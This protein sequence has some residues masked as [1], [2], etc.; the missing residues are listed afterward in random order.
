MEGARPPPYP[1]VIRLR[2][3][4]YMLVAVLLALT[5]GPAG[6][7]SVDWSWSPS[8]GVY[9]KNAPAPA[10]TPAERL[11]WALL[12]KED[13]AP[14][15]DAEDLDDRVE[16]EFARAAAVEKGVVLPAPE[17]ARRAEERMPALYEEPAAAPQP[18]KEPFS[19]WRRFPKPE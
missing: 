17:P 11:G 15:A 9:R 4:G 13:E 16:R 10:P 19:M 1:P 2:T 12:G 6:A 14:P 3:E 7:Q 8:K 5:A 18:P